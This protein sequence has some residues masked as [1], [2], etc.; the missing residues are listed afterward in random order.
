MIEKAKA[1]AIHSHEITNHKYDSRPY[2]HHLQMVYNNALLHIHL[3]PKESQETVLAACWVHDVIEDCRQTYND[4]KANT[5]EAVADI[6]Y[7][8]TNEKGKTREQRAGKIYYDGIRKTPFATFVKVCD[9]IA[10]YEYSIA[11]GSMMAVKYEKEMVHFIATL[12]DTKYKEL[13]DYLVNIFNN[14]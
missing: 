5:N 14:S 6:A 7:A 13:F 8:L 1:Y 2:S 4:V 11:T 10:N 12:D 3:I 9:R